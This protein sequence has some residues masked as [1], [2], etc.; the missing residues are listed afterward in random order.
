MPNLIF[1][2]T[3]AENLFQNFHLMQFLCEIFFK[4]LIKSRQCQSYESKNYMPK[5]KTNSCGS[6]LT[7][8]VIAMGC[9][10]N[11]VAISLTDRAFLICTGSDIV[12]SV[13]KI[14]S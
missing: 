13:F 11:F 10:W 7:A 14:S 2:E 3:Y 12:S 4:R 9:E 6:N 5:F 1:H 8:S